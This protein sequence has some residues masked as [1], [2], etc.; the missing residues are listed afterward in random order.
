MRSVNIVNMLKVVATV[1]KFLYDSF[2]K[3]KFETEYV[4]PLYNQSNLKYRQE[5]D[6]ENIWTPIYKNLEVSLQ[7]STCYCEQPSQISIRNNGEDSI[8]KVTILVK[9]EGIFDGYFT[10][11][12]RTKRQEIEFDLRDS[13][14]FNVEILY[15]VPPINF[16][17]V[18]N[19]NIIYSYETLSVSVVSIVTNNVCYELKSKPEI[20]SNSKGNFL[21]DVLK[22]N[23]IQKAGRYYNIRHINRAKRNL[24]EK[25]WSD[26][27]PPPTWV[28]YEEFF[29][30]NPFLKMYWKLCGLMNTILCYVL[31]QEK[32]L[33]ARFWLFIMLN[34]Q[35]VNKHGDLEFEHYSLF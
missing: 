34:R 13:N 26:L 28:S 3:K 19:G 30:L 16:W 24:G 32:V 22:G 15:A 11:R 4:L 12:Y 33:A 2:F 20:R 31:L 14:S 5:N 6:L 9:A 29:R 7:M 21:D 35:S 17:T 27:N 8:D 23:W 25:I 1:S 18:E 10:D